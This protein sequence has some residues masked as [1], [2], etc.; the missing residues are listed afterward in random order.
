MCFW[1]TCQSRWWS[2]LR[3]YRIFHLTCQQL[4]ALKSMRQGIISL[5]VLNRIDEHSY[6][7][8]CFRSYRRE[9]EGHKLLWKEPLLYEIFFLD[10]FCRFS[11]GL[12][13]PRGVL[14]CIIWTFTGARRGL[15][16][17]GKLCNS[18]QYWC[19]SILTF[20]D[21]ISTL[22]ALPDSKSGLAALAAD[23]NVYHFFMG[24]ELG[25]LK[26]VL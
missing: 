10:F 6:G 21:G 8:V 16:V 25:L 3:Y 18:Y 5:N 23:R 9:Q 12:Y 24:S 4:R 26:A 19:D 22:P 15:V 7:T 17:D 11:G 14:L 2:V 20:M 1:F 13:S